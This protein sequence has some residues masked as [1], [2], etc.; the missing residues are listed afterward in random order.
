MKA[1]KMNVSLRMSV[2]PSACHTTFTANGQRPWPRMQ[3]FDVRRYQRATLRTTRRDAANEHVEE[4]REDQAE[5]GDAKHPREHGDAHHVAHLRARATGENE[6]H[7]AHDECERRHENRTQSD[8]RRLER[9]AQTIATLLLEIACKLYDEDGVLARETD[10]HEQPDL[11]EDV[12]VST[13]DPHAGDRRQKAHR[14]DENDHERQR[15][16]FVLRGEHEENEQ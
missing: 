10:E 15:P 6:R 16:A 12:V 8:A 7:D 1:T 14:H 13:R 11:S 3:W 9:G 4:R 5:E 2:S